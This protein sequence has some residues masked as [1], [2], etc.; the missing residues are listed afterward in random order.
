MTV[1]LQRADRE[2]IGLDRNRL[3]A[4]L[5]QQSV[6][7]L[8]QLFLQHDPS[9][10]NGGFGNFD[11]TEIDNE[12]GRIPERQQRAGAGA[13]PGEIAAVDIRSD[14]GG[15]RPLRQRHAQFFNTVQCVPILSTACKYRSL[16]VAASSACVPADSQMTVGWQSYL[17]SISAS[18]AKKGP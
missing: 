6:Q 1:L 10:G 9:T 14:Q 18:G 5:F 13:Q 12:I 8:R 11:I 3:G 16:M 4:V 7:L 15:V 17:T 2:I